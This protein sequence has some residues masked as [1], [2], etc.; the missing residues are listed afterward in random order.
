VAFFG[1]VNFFL[2]H[3]WLMGCFIRKN[4]F[5]ALTYSGRFESWLVAGLKKIH[6][7]V[8]NTLVMCVYV[9][10]SMMG[11]LKSAHL[12]Y[13]Y[14]NITFIM[15]DAFFKMT[16]FTSKVLIRRRYF[17]GREACP[18]QCV[19]LVYLPNDMSIFLPFNVLNYGY[20]YLCPF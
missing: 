11:P 20:A 15:Y 10:A 1:A 18:N 16:R 13:S 4:I 8:V 2:F 14:F 3:M 9:C 12:Y 19:E 17:C 7:I 6:W 5:Y